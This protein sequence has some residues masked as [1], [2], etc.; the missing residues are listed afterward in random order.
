MCRKGCSKLAFLGLL[1]GLLT[2]SVLAA[3]EPLL[4]ESEDTLLSVGRENPFAVIFR[5]PEP[6]DEQIIETADVNNAPEPNNSASSL[7]DIPPLYVG[8]VVV[9]YLKAASLTS[10]LQKLASDRGSVSADDKSNSLI[11][12]DTQESLIRILDEVRRIDRPTDL[13]AVETITLKFLDA[14]ELKPA[15]EGMLSHFGSISVD[16]KSNSLI[17]SDTKENMDKIRAEIR[18][19]DQTPPQIMIEVVL[20]DVQLNDDTEIGV[21]WDILSDLTYD[22]SYRQSLGFTTRLGSTIENSTTRGNATAFNTTGTGGDFALVSGT[23]RNV[24]HMIQEKKNIEILA[25]PRVMVLSGKTATI[26]AVEEIPYN[27]ITETSGGGQL[28]STEF[29][30]VGVTLKVGATLTDDNLIYLTVDAEQNV[31][32]EES[33]T[34]VPVVDTRNARTE[35]LLDDGRL[36]VFGGLRRKETKIQVEQ[37]PLL[38]DLPLIG[39]LFRSTS[40]VV[41]N[42]ELIVFLSPHIYKGEPIGDDE[43]AKYDEI[44]KR[45]MLAIPVQQEKSLLEKIVR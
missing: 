31:Q 27:E 5:K 18:K 42:S 30:D 36:V 10:A 13:M 33:D 6:K 32:T 40:K 39:F 4:A 9:R 37:I 38:G 12:C 17:I 26:K 16:S 22:V 20:V 11:I 24:I 23:I 41:N 2:A 43:T 8:T 45:P 14:K 21:N 44:T 1:A 35:L 29:K 19:A 25:S 28:S 15:I 3:Q 34:G 7:V